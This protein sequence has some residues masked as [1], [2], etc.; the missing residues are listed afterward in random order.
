MYIKYH[1][2]AKKYLISLEI[3]LFS[4]YCPSSRCEPYVIESLIMFAP[5]PNRMFKAAHSL[6]FV[7]FSFLRAYSL[8]D[9][10]QVSTF[11]ISILLI[12]YGSFRWV[13]SLGT[14]ISALSKAQRLGDKVGDMSVGFSLISRVILFFSKDKMSPNFGFNFL[15]Q[16]WVCDPTWDY[17]EFRLG[18]LKCLV[19]DWKIRIIR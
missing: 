18:G 17:L 13:R 7:F 8:V 2:S 19:I 15:F 12:V 11:L 9:S 4:P 10:S 6:T 14:G 1:H 5:S 16:P 3:G